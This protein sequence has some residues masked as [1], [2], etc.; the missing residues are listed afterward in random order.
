MTFDGQRADAGSCVAHVQHMSRSCRR[1]KELP[2]RCSCSGTCFARCRS[3][4]GDAE[5]RDVA[6]PARSDV[7]YAGSTPSLGRYEAVPEGRKPFEKSFG[8]GMGRFFALPFLGSSLATRRGDGVLA[9]D[10]P[11]FGKALRG[12]A[13]PSAKAFRM[14]VDRHF[15]ELASDG[16]TG[17]DDFRHDPSI[18]LPSRN[19]RPRRA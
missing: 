13:K 14:T 19:L 3:G 12:F 16:L 6:A 4:P 18:R 15:A 7:A 5:V 2:R 11:G 10:L 8:K 9:S 1:S 17:H